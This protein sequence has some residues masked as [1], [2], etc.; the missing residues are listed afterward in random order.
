MS[1]FLLIII[2]RCGLN[3]VTI[4]PLVPF[5]TLLSDLQ[6]LNPSDNHHQSLSEFDSSSNILKNSF[7]PPAK[8]KKG[9]RP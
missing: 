4:E 5:L 1:C 9:L 7:N 8:K 6:G 3:G 2:D